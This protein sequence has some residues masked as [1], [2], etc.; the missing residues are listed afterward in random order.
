MA[1]TSCP[2]C[3]FELD[4]APWG[5]SGASDEIC[6]SCG[7]QFG[8]NDARIDLRQHVYDE[9]RA[10]WIANGRK[11]LDGSAWREASTRIPERAMM[12]RVRQLLDILGIARETSMQGVGIS[13]REALHRTRY[14]DLRAGLQEA[15]LLCLLRTHPALGKDWIEYSEDKR[16]SGGWYILRNGEIGQ[17]DQA[18]A[19]VRFAS[20]E[21][22]VAAYVLRELDFWVNV[23]AD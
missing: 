17:V 7:I 3:E 20:I 5:D 12:T 23:N 4:F 21:E 18:T 1:E 2:V 11:A 13:L 9:W 15:D 19:R 14:R 8:Y 22:A 10:A 6:P 16:T